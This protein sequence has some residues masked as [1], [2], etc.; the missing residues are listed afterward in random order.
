METG[1]DA[2]LTTQG[3]AEST[4]WKQDITDCR[5]EPDKG[6]SC[7]ARLTFTPDLHRDR[8]SDIIC[9]VSH[10]S[11]QRALEKT[12]GMLTVLG[13]PTVNP[14]EIRTMTSTSNAKTLSLEV[15]YFIPGGKDIWWV[16]VPTGVLPSKLHMTPN[17]DGTHT[18]KSTC[19]PDKSMRKKMKEHG[20]I[21][22][23]IQHEALDKA[24]KVA[25]HYKGK[26]KGWGL[27][28]EADKALDEALEVLAQYKGKGKGWEMLKEADEQERKKE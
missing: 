18:A 5:H 28:K 13:V 15:D 4:V 12:T 2:R 8:G 10:P 22:V 17:Q 23:I 20:I 16:C 25:A 26:G 27:Q 19:E 7:T 24:L 1:S 9:R 11:L 3:D 14:W 6:H 21:T